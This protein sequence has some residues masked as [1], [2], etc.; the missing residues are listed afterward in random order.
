MTATSLSWALQLQLASLY[1]I[2]IAVKKMSPLVPIGHQPWA[3]VCGQGLADFT[4]NSNG[5]N[6]IYPL[7]PTCT[8]HGFNIPPFVTCSESGSNSSKFL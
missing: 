1:A 2:L 6:K 5:D 4:A 8:Y 7:R 3:K